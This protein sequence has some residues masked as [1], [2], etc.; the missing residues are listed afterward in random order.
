MRPKVFIG[1]SREGIEIARAFESNLRK[2]AEVTLWDENVF[3]I[4]ETTIDALITQLEQSDHGVF[5]L[6]PDDRVYIRDSQGPVARDNVI[7]EL[8]LFMG[9]L[10]KQRCFMVVPDEPDLHLPSDLIGITTATYDASRVRK[11]PQPATGS[12]CNQIREAIKQGSG[13]RAQA[14]REGRRPYTFPV[15]VW[16]NR[17]VTFYHNVNLSEYTRYCKDLAQSADRLFT[18]LMI[19]P[20]EIVLDILR[21]AKLKDMDR[22]TFIQLA[23]REWDHYRAYRDHERTTRLIV[24]D[25]GGWI[26]RNRWALQ[27]MSWLNGDIPCYVVD[28]S[29]LTG[30]QRKLMMIDHTVADQDFCMYDSLAK[31]LTIAKADHRAWEYFGYEGV[32]SWMSKA[33]GFVALGDFVGAKVSGDG[34]V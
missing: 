25:G 9:H 34:R 12:A 18:M 24:R 15:E 7:F 10:G 11:A 5:I 16:Q 21:G 4:S 28:K 31:I 23:D 29:I 8:G 33:S 2:D 17:N 27:A 13:R 26:K 30:H 3:K 20:R 22:D 14:I 19:E 6:S 32:D 1:S